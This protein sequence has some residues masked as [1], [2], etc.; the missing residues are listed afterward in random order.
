MFAGKRNEKEPKLVVLVVGGYVIG[1]FVNVSSIVDD[2]NGL[3]RLLFQQQYSSQG[4]GSDWVQDR[5]KIW[6]SGGDKGKR[7]NLIPIVQVQLTK[8][9][10]IEKQKY[11]KKMGN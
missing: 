10:F 6:K 9:C 8:N 7:L 4:D 11:N 2:E 1:I 5:R 3:G